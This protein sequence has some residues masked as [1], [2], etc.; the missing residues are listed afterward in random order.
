MGLIALLK[1]VPMRNGSGLRAEF[2]H[3]TS[4]TEG[5]AGRIAPSCVGCV[6]KLWVSSPQPLFKR[7]VLQQRMNRKCIKLPQLAPASSISPGE[8]WRSCITLTI[9]LEVLRLFF[10]F[11]YTKFPTFTDLK[12]CYRVCN[13]S[14]RNQ[15]QPT[16][17]ALN[18]KGH[19]GRADHP[20]LAVPAVVQTYTPVFQQSSRIVL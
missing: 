2:E 20:H 15:L 5:A 7:R 10:C 9:V 4:K 12:W 3:K 6:C 13:I 11:S 16:A 18:S 19:A 1:R 14:W 8:S 17:F